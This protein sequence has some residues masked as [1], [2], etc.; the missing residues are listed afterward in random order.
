M[1]LETFDLSQAAY[2]YGLAN[3][4]LFLVRKLQ[5][6]PAI[7]AIS[8]SCSEDVIL[9]SLR[10]LMGQEPTSAL[11]A[12]KPYAYLVALWFKPEIGPLQQAAEM[13]TRA[14]QWYSYVAEVLIETYS[15]V[16]T[17]LIE[18]PGVLPAPSVTP[19]EAPTSTRV[20]VAP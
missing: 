11:E 7:R 14:H 16:Q 19:E 12:V 10:L 5:D 20:I 3:T 4:P 1:N 6:D 17:Q 2:T 8:N 18:V 9:Q 13:K 15:P